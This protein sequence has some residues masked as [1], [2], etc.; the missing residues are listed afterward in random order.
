M[1]PEQ[2]KQVIMVVLVIGAIG[3]VLYQLLF[4]S[5]T[6]PSL[7]GDAQNTAATTTS[8]STTPSAQP[9]TFQEVDVNIDDL[10]QGIQ[11]VN[12]DYDLERTDRNPM[13]PLVGTLMLS[14]DLPTAQA[15]VVDALRKSVTGIVW[16]EFDPFAVVDNEVVH[17]GYVYPDG[18]QVHTINPNSVVFK[19]GDALVSID[20]KEL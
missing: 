14:E 12:F 19:V 16:D 10:L 8:R 9:V 20:M 11:V 2:R 15:R 18:I 3:V 13:S 1:T 4:T 6:T 17:I 7:G 5:I